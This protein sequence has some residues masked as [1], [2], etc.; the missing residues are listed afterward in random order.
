MAGDLRLISYI[1]YRSCVSA[2]EGRISTPAD[3]QEAAID[4]QLSALSG[5]SPATG[6]CA[7]VAVI[8]LGRPQVTP[9]TSVECQLFEGLNSH[10]RPAAE[11]WQ[12][13]G[14]MRCSAEIAGIFVRL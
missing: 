11:V 13:F 7:A 2:R 4:C 8:K 3:A 12:D 6:K 5:C 14:C 10:C 9:P 1:A